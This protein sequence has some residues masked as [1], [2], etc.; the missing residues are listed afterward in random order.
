M[1]ANVI[2]WANTKG[3]VGKTT[4]LPRRTRAYG[5]DTIPALSPIPSIFSFVTASSAEC[6]QIGVGALTTTLTAE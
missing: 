5:F 3:G 2:A 4:S 1:I 6:V